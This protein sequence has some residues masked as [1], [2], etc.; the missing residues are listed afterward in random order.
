MDSPRT[1][2]R[3]RRTLGPVRA[4]ATVGDVAPIDTIL[5]Y[6]PATS[7]EMYVEFQFKPGRLALPDIAC[8]LIWTGQ[9]LRVIGPMRRGLV[10]DGDATSMAL[11][12]LDTRQAAALLGMPL[13][14][15]TDLQPSIRD[16][17]PA[18]AAPLEDLF[19]LGGAA[20]RARAGSATGLG[21]GRPTSA[22]AMLAAGASPARASGSS[23]WT[24]RH[25]R[26]RFREVFG[27]SPGEFRRVTRFRRAVRAVR[28]GG[29]L[30]EAALVG[31][32]ADQPHFN[33]ECQELMGLPPRAVL[34][35][36]DG[37]DAAEGL[38]VGNRSESAGAD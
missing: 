4:R 14:E 21:T 30:A 10:A 22:A 1:L 32:Y 3:Q 31:G 12:T 33:R 25:F 29:S 7:G 19:A 8:D 38:A 37:V 36:L 17:A 20:A 9:D 11:L 24:S 26:R 15:L 5:R 18:L 27:L 6:L 34:A 13:G 35:G 2:R 23:D 16:V 28:A